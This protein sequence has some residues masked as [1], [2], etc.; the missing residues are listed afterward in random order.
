MA[1]S[2]F[3]DRLSGRSPILFLVSVMSAMITSSHAFHLSL[4]E[5]DSCPGSYQ[6]CGTAGLPDTFCCPSSST[7]VGLDNASS[8]ICCPKGQACTYIEPITCNVQLQN[9]TLHPKNPIKTTRLNDQLPKCG[10]SCCPFGYRCKGNQ[11]CEMDNAKSSTTALDGNSTP[12]VTGTSSTKSIISTTPDALSTPEQVKPTTLSRSDTNPSTSNSPMTDTSSTSTPITAA[13]PSFPT[14]AVIAGFFP[15]VVLGAVLASAAFFCSRRCR[16]KRDNTHTK[17]SQHNGRVFNG[18]PLSISHP[19]P[20][21]DS[22]YRTDFLLRRS[23]R[24]STRSMLQRTGSRVKSLF[25]SN[26]KFTVHDLDKAPPVPITPPR[27]VRRQLSTESI[28]VYTPPGGLANTRTLKQGRYLSVEPHPNFTDMIGEVGFRDKR[29][30]PC[31]KVV[32]SPEASR[33][34]LQRPRNV[35]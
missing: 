32:E 25:G 14:L 12:T 3:T 19:I 8:A 11:L 33:A 21:E 29:G 4:R 13:C 17:L 24:S 2:N 16:N 30:E 18:A 26:P 9:A 35:Y 20:S 6:K 1:K 28:R 15:G 10:N 31:F 7:C 5:S 27:Q 22:S 23:H 34:D